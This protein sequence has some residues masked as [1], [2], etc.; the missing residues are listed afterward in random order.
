V[1]GTRDGAA[2]GTEP[3]RNGVCGTSACGKARTDRPA[4]RR[5]N[6]GHGCRGTGEHGALADAS[7]DGPR[8]TPNPRRASSFEAE[9]WEPSSSPDEE[10][11]MGERDASTGTIPKYFGHP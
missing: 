5:G 9:G 8:P 11:G 7:N 1:G 10:P 4:G 3:R 6:D 2:V